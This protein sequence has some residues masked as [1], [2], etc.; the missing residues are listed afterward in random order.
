MDRVAAPAKLTTSLAMVGLR[1]DGYHLLEA[2][3]VTISLADT[4]TITPEGS[5]FTMTATPQSRAGGLVDL[6]R[7]LCL[8]ALGLVDRRAAIDLD[9]VIPVGGGLGGGSADAAAVLRWANCDDL[10]LAAQLGS[11]VPFC[12][13]G[14]RAA[15]SGVGEIVEP[16]RHEDR[17]FC[18][19]VP[20][21]AI[22]TPEVY[23]A[24]DEVG[25]Q[26]LGQ[27]HRNDLYKAAL[28]VSPALASVVAALR[29]RTGLTPSLAGSG[30]TLFYE[31]T[32]AQVAL[33]QP[34]AV[35][36]ISLEV[37]DVV[38]VPPGWNGEGK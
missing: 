25:L 30:S 32:S 38:T 16:L 1:S 11:D 8:D 35:D 23:R 19:I 2:E 21:C 10:N 28:T 13:L 14:G 33:D 20:D 31:G 36:G 15:V 24:F 6:E 37:Y 27:A 26:D 34:L 22:S 17:A 18:L 5:G 29:A 9:K 7:N 12:V 4:L 3:M